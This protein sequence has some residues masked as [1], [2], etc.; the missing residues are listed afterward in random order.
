MTGPATNPPPAWSRLR[1]EA[2]GRGLPFQRAVD[3]ALLR[4][5]PGQQQSE[6]SGRG[7]RN[8]AGKNIKRPR[9]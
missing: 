1:D 6:V 5:I 8:H 9:K 3:Y 7:T 4:F 2:L